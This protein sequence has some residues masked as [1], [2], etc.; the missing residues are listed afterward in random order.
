LDQQ[1]FAAVASP[2]PPGGHAKAL[3]DDTEGAL[4]PFSNQNESDMS[5]IIKQEKHILLVLNE[6]CH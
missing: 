1:T 3:L 4:P 2:L 6:L 5:Q